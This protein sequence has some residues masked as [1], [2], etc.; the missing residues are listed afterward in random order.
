M[1]LVANLLKTLGMAGYFFFNNLS[2]AMK[3]NIVSGISL[4][5]LLGTHAHHTPGVDCWRPT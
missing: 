3:F 2:W 5:L 1:L 4:S